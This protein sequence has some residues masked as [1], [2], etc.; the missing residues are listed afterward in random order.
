MAV[1]FLQGPIGPFFKQLTLA[2]REQGL[3][4]FNINFNGGDAWFNRGLQALDYTGCIEEWPSFLDAFIRERA[5]DTVCVFGDCRSY[6][7]AAKSICKRLGVR[8]FAFEEG[9]LRPNHITFEEGGVNANSPINTEAVKRWRNRKI[10]SD[11]AVSDMN[12]GCTLKNRTKFCMTYYFL[13]LLLCRRFKNCQHHR[14]LSIPHEILCWGRAAFRHH[15]YKYTERHLLKHIV[16]AHHKRYFLLPLQ[17]YNDAQLRFHSPYNSM[18][19]CIKEV[20][21][22]FKQHAPKDHLLVI[23]HHPMDRGHVHYG[24]LIQSLG[25]RY[26]IADRLVYCH[27][28]HLPTLLSSTKGVVTINSTTALSALYHRAPVKVLGSACYDIP[29][30]CSQQLL[31]QFLAKPQKF[32]FELYKKFNNY[33]RYHGQVN[34]S[35][36]GQVALSV[37]NMLVEMQRKKIGL[38]NSAQIVDIAKTLSQKTVV[39]H[40]M[41]DAALNSH[42]AINK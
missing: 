14:S 15:L 35:F 2:L 16:K 10:G 31:S 26:D 5:V 12:V 27:D 19:Q 11:V 9:Y 33:L 39:T 37:S 13:S 41:Q 40:E 6:H 38:Q 17:V 30:L 4:V 1:L 22:S 7:R 32:D 29:G 23:K 34:G 20:V 8:F 36:Y 18:E 21:E 3:D 24:Q 25:E 28:L 42:Y